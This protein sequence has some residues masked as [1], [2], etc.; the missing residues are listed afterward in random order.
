MC[1]FPAF[2]LPVILAT[3]IPTVAQNNILNNSGFENGLM[4]YSEWVWSNTGQ[5]YVG[6]YRFSLSSDAHSG[7]YSL[8]ISCSGTD[9]AK[10]A[11]TS[12]SIPAPANQSYI[13]NV[14]AKCPSG[15]LAA[16]YIPG[17]ANGDVGQ[18]LTCDGNWDLNQVTFETGAAA[19]YLTYAF[20]SYGTSWALIDDVVLT[21]GDGTAPQHTVLYPGVRNVSTSG[22][23]VMVD[24]APFLSLGFFDV[25]YN[26][27]GQVAATGANTINGLPKYNATNCF[28]TGQTSY[29]DRLYQ[30]GLNFVPDSTTT[31]ELVTPTVFPTVTQTYAPH[32]ANIAWLLADEP[33]QSNVGWLY[34]PASTFIAEA[35]AAR[36][37]TSLPMMADFQKAS[38]GTT[39]D[40]APYNGSA[41]IWMAEPYGADFSGINNAVNIFNAIQQRPIWLAQDDTGASVI[42]P[43]AYWAVIAG[44]TG[45]HYFDWDTFKADPPSLTAVEQVFSELKGLNNAIFGQKMDSLVTAPGGVASMSRFDPAVGTA[46]ILAANNS[47]Q[48]VQGNFLVQGLTSGQTVSVLYENRTI[49]AS[50]GRF[51]DS[52]AGVSRHVYAINSPTTSLTATLANKTGA[53]ASRDWQIQVYN[54]GIGAANSAQISN[55]VFTQTGGTVCTPTVSPGTYPV[56]LGNIAP[57][58]SATGNMILN[59]TGCDT[60]SK[61]TVKFI[62]AANSGA[63][64]ATVSFN[65]ERL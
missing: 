64:N 31:A 8:E 62:V 41:N 27:L 63:T 59:F 34:I 45:I 26:D 57:A 18:W 24:G 2:V 65:N 1:R 9:C 47:T 44:A 54:T 22:Q 52:F 32:L 38:Y 19:G 56:A 40:I 14:W 25:G 50:A 7:A 5:N 13:L 39:I 53:T 20:Y 49:T 15:G 29:L 55:L 4:C 48:T 43:K 10:G 58:Q 46:Y 3:G 30:L 23:T 16:A 37:Q 35:T 61:F 60:T 33:D 12:D 11:I 51:Y 42:V 17:M 6:D 21:F 36:T 28:N